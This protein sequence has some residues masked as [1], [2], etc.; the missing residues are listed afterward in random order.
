MKATACKTGLV[1][2]AAIATVIGT[3]GQ[4][5]A[6]PRNVDRL[7]PNMSDAERNNSNNPYPHYKVIDTGSFGG[8]NS[9]IH[10]GAHV[11]NDAGVLTVSADTP[12][13]DPY[14]PDG[15]FN[16][17]CLVT[18]TAKWKQGELKDLGVVGAGPNSESNWLSENGLIVGDSQNGMLDPLVGAWQ[19]RGVFWKHNKLVEVGTL[20]GGYNSL[21]WAVNDSGEVV[22][23]STTTVPDDYGMILQ[24]GLPYAY[25]TRAFVWK[26]GRI[27]DLGT[28]G[29]PDAMAFGINEGGQIIGNSYT[30]SEISTVCGLTTG[31]F[32]WERGKMMNLGSLGGTCTQVSAINNRGQVVGSSFLA[33]DAVL[34]PFLW[35]RG[36]LIDLGTSGG[37]FASANFVNEAGDIAGVQTVAGNDGIVHA[38]I[39]SRGRVFDLGAPGPGQCSYAWG[40]NARRQVVGLTSNDCDFNDELSLRAFLWEPGRPMVD[41]NTL[42]S[43]GLGIQ[44]RNIATIN[45][46][47]EMAAVAAF[48][49]G[50][51][52]PVILVP[53]GKRE[54][55]DAD[56]RDEVPLN[57]GVVQQKSNGKSLAAIPS[58][59]EKSSSVTAQIQM[60][61]SRRRFGLSV[62]K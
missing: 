7:Q 24:L 17:D 45:D 21:A 6:M 3:Y 25:Q 8:S 47:G 22:G 51:H 12:D 50:D 41:V 58:T 28:L 42:I 56:C 4:T 38:T 54:D 5:D 39:W 1:I 23:F 34:H 29:G 60:L 33:G 32:L 15:C 36:R 49:N 48:A 61:L 13:T 11:L 40:I 26:E 59:K 35:E 62:D 18:H 43:P 2:V 37:N 27:E 31:G 19:L 57:S 16:G 9:H 46:R 30:S 20:G 52:R 44:L 14:S 53:C 55:N 10:L